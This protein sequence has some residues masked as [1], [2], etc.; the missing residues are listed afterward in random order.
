MFHSYSIKHYQV[1]SKTRINPYFEHD[2]M[3]VIIKARTF[4]MME[5]KRDLQN[6]TEEDIQEHFQI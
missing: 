2:R 1:N 6:L 3:Q 4:T 5:D